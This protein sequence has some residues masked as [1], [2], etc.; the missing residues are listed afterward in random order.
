MLNFCNS[1]D[2]PRCFG[3]FGGNDSA[4]DFDPRVNPDIPFIKKIITS[5][6]FETE[7]RGILKWVAGDFTVKKRKDHCSRTILSAPALSKKYVLAAR[8]AYAKVIGKKKVAIGSGD[9]D[10]IVTAVDASIRNNLHIKVILSRTLS[11]DKE[12]TASLRNKGAEVDDRTCTEY[13]DIPYS[14]LEVPMVRDP[15]AYTLQVEANYGLWPR[16][17]LTGIFA[18]LYGYDLLEKIG[19]VPEACVI[20]ITTGTEA[21]GIIKGFPAA[22]CKIA[23]AEE[24]IAGENHTVN[25]G[26]YS[27]ATR[28]A[29]KEQEN[30]V[31][32]PELVSLW[33]R[34]QVFRL[35]CDRIHAVDTSA[36]TGVGLSDPGA[37]AAA[38]A[39]EHFTCREL[40]VVEVE[41]T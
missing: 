33:R 17:G 31:L 15:E 2:L 16:P 10:M 1:I 4:G 13:F 19:H 27:I 18:G 28:S 5:D 21:L 6:E 32:C 7:F 38:L 41:N 29:G 12:F 26:A 37:R 34:N 23:T 35:G 30:T 3:D 14:Y 11:S 22:D 9:K 8:I 24:L 25:A 20:P 40:L 36:L 39:L